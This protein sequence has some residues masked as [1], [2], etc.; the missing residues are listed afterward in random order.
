M[1]KRKFLIT[2]EGQYYGV[3]D[4]TGVANVKK[5][6]AKFILPSL[7]AALSVICKYL[8]DPY[9]KK[10]YPDYAKF[11]SHKITSVS[12][13]G[14]LP[15]ATVLQMAFEDMGVADLSD[16]CILKQIMIDPYVHK[17]LEACRQEVKTIYQSRAD[18][19][20]ADKESKR[21]VEKN[22]VDKLLAMNQLPP[23]EEGA[24]I[25]V[26]QQRIMSAGKKIDAGVS[27]TVEP[28][29]K[30]LPEEE[31]KENPLGLE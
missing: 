20:R 23:Q 13:E 26:N 3:H 19:Q 15:D 18:Q 31:E 21:D 27:T 2:V 1:E 5:Y 7:E 6:T 8:L 24:T 16:F 4:L 10:H 17:D 28:E 22:E 9:L 30:P 12:T 14:R 25:S 11:R 29:D